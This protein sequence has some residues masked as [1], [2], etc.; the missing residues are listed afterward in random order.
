[1]EYIITNHVQNVLSVQCSNK[2]GAGNYKEGLRLQ[3]K[4]CA[5]YEILIIAYRNYLRFQKV[6]SLKRSHM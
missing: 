4:F 5:L 2:H 3:K 6:W 1:M